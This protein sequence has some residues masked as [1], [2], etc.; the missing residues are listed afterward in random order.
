[1]G[2]DDNAPRQYRGYRFRNLHASDHLEGIDHV[3]AFNDPLIDN[4][5]SK[6]RYRAGV[7]IEEEIAKFGDKIE[8]EVAKARKRFGESFGEAMFRQT[9]PRVLENQ[10]K[11]G[12]PS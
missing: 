5:D 9:N 10:K 4:K 6:K 11:R 12:E 3:D 8:K 7:L 1:M 2:S